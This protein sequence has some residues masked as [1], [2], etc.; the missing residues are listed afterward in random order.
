MKFI[1][2]FH[3]T[4]KITTN[5]IHLWNLRFWGKSTTYLKSMN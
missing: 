3:H 1:I 5:S 4:F 2:G